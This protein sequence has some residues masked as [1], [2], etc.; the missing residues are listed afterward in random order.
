MNHKGI[1][2][3]KVCARIPIWQLTSLGIKPHHHALAGKNYSW[4]WY[5]FTKNCN[6]RWHDQKNRSFP[7]KEVYTMAPYLPF[8]FSGF[9]GPKP[10]ELHESRQNGII[11][12]RFVKD[13]LWNPKISYETSKFLKPLEV[14]RNKEK[15]KFRGKEIK[16]IWR[17]QQLEYRFKKKRKVKKIG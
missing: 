17:D 7:S 10:R 15:V 11:F 12:L 13:F 6:W 8:T 14:I 9:N 16:T 4:S 1:H 2:V 3:Q 5:D